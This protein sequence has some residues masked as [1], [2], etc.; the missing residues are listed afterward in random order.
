MNRNEVIEKEIVPN[1]KD[2]RYN[3]D[4]QAIVAS[5][6]EADDEG[7]YSK[8]ATDE[9]Y[10]NIVENFRF[11]GVLN[12]GENFW[13]LRS[14]EGEEI[15]SGTFEADIFPEDVSIFE[16][17]NFVNDGNEKFTI[18]DNGWDDRTYDEIA[19]NVIIKERK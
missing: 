10:A 5:A 6:Y 19:L 7:N 13:E 2:S 14:A 4:L 16:L 8:S 12:A 3:Y 15:E 18:E 9:E 11:G 1:L 17:V